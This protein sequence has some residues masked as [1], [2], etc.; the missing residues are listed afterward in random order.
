MHNIWHLPLPCNHAPLTQ[1]LFISATYNFTAFT[2]HTP[3]THNITAESLS[4][5]LRQAR[6][7]SVTSPYPNPN[8]ATL[9][10][11][12]NP[13]LHE[14]LAHSIRATYTSGSRSFIHFCLTYNC[15]NPDS[16]ILPASEHTL[17][18]FSTYLA[19]SLKPQSIKVY[20]LSVWN[21]HLEHGFAAP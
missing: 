10:S 12:M 17:M 13:F 21:F 9:T 8:L 15:I 14:A 3:S 6:P 20:L 5:C 7:R 2:Q 1:P 4:Q 11:D 19:Y 16:H 18:P